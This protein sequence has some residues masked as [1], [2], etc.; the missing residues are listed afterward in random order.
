EAMISSMTPEERRDPELINGSRRQ[1]IA[2]GSGTTVTE[3]NKLLKQ[4][5][6]TR[7][8]MKLM[9]DKKKMANM[10]RQMQAMQGMKR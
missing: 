9:G 4:F 7:K 8:M 10:M 2:S 1:R 5:G 3:V 6:E